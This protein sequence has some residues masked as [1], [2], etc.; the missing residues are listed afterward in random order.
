[1]R[2][3]AVLRQ[4]AATRL[5]EA[6]NLANFEYAAA[7]PVV[8]V[9]QCAPWSSLQALQHATGLENAQDAN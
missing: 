6:E 3:G 1:M 9:T 2:R 4:A 7:G 8:M 5:H